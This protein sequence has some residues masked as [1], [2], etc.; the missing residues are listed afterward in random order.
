MIYIH[1]TP[2]YVGF[3]MALFI[4]ILYEYAILFFV[5]PFMKWGKRKLIP[6]LKTLVHMDLPR[7]RGAEAAG[8]RTICVRSRANQ[9]LMRV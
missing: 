1:G 9:R 6:T 8:T 7:T 4:S 5:F 3:D 2:Y